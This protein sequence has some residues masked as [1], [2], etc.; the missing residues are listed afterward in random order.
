M[1]FTA[2]RMQ[3]QNAS[4]AVWILSAQDSNFLPH[5]NHSSLQIKLSQKLLIDFL[6]DKHI[7][8]AQEIYCQ[9]GHLSDYSSMMPSGEYN[10]C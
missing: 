7:Q 9:E 2:G 3:R 5:Q 10:T 4:I 6:E 1:R 8:E